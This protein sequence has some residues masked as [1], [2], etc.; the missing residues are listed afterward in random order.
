MQLVWLIQAKQ[1]FINLLHN[2][3]NKGSLPQIEETI[4]QCV[5]EGNFL[6]RQGQKACIRFFK[7]LVANA[8][9]HG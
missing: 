9:H 4:P 7:E 6:Y 3:S 8:A 5:V 1:K 2:S